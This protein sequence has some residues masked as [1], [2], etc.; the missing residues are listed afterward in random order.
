MSLLVQHPGKDKIVM[1]IE[2]NTTPEE[3]EFYEYLYYI[4]R[5]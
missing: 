2:E 1:I 3:D 4:A 5:I